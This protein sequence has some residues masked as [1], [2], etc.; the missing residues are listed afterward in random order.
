MFDAIEILQKEVFPK[1]KG[2]RATPVRPTPIAMM[3]M[4]I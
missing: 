3:P 2:V 4:N 1:M